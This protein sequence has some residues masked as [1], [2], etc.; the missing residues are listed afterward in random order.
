MSARPLAAL[1]HLRL[2][3]W[4]DAAWVKPESP[5]A[6]RAQPTAGPAKQ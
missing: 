4:W 2:A 5:D 3:G 6:A 1:A